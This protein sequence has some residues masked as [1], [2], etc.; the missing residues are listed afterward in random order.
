MKNHR[1]RLKQPIAVS[2]HFHC[3]GVAPSDYKSG[4]M[5]RIFVCL[6][7]ATLALYLNVAKVAAQTFAVQGSKGLYA[8]AE[9]NMTLLYA[10]DVNGFGVSPNGQHVVFAPYGGEYGGG[11]L[12]EDVEAELTKVVSLPSETGMGWSE[13]RYTPTGKIIGR[14]Y[15]GSEEAY[16]IFIMNIDGSGVRKLVSGGAWPVVSSKGALAYLSS[17]EANSDLYVLDPSPSGKSVPRLLASASIYG[18]TG[19]PPSFS[20]DG[21]DILF[22]RT[23]ARYLVNLASGEL[24]VVAANQRSEWETA[25]TILEVEAFGI[26]R[27]NFGTFKRSTVVEMPSKG[28]A[29]W[30]RSQP[31]GG[32]AEPPE[33]LSKE[34]LLQALAPELRF[35]SQEPY[36][37]DAASELTE[38][39][40]FEENGDLYTPLLYNESNEVLADPF[41]EEQAF[42]EEHNH[43]VEGRFALWFEALGS[44]YPGFTYP[45]PEGFAQSGDWVDEHNG[46]HMADAA[47]LHSE[48]YGNVAYGRIVEEGGELWLQYWFWYYYN[49]GVL[50]VGDHEGDW[51]MVQ[52]HLDSSTYEPDVVVFSEHAHASRC[53]TG[54]FQT[55]ATGAPVV[56]VANGSHASY[57]EEGEYET[58][59]P[60][61]DDSVFPNEEEV[62]AV[63][64]TV[65]DLAAEEPAW[66]DW[67]GRWGGSESSPHGPKA[68]EPQ[69]SDP[70]TWAEEAGGCLDSKVGSFSRMAAVNSAWRLGGPQH[71]PIEVTDARMVG[72]RIEI[73]YRSARLRQSR[74]GWPKLLLSVDATGDRLPPKS[75]VA[76]D[77]NSS[78]HF[79]FPFKLDRKKHWRVRASLYAPKVRSTT[80]MR[81]VRAK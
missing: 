66:V 77:L 60:L 16:G 80:V 44:Y 9:G 68:H 18:I 81:R 48:G 3:R 33:A 75:V 24:T 70:D 12:I 36:F 79:T 71:R 59:V 72:R 22:P 40:D 53:T 55:S 37:A 2:T 31:E 5:V 51:E 35:D 69:W 6:L 34:G 63:V 13:V 42:A 4:R 61:I 15:N 7:V 67:P 11:V 10:G 17:D 27:Y 73:G 29:Y 14:A 58:E 28:A 41:F 39:S 21:E 62:P 45:D 49:N 78:G 38:A 25:N 54:E 56:Y 50:G 65:V 23:S 19:G 32:E 57:P 8:N 20:P 52:A 26:G 47:R 30:V 46:T 43:K 76:D 64:P 1:T 74:S